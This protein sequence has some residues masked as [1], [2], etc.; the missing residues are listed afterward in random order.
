MKNWIFPHSATDSGITVETTLSEG[1]SRIECCL[2]RGPI[3]GWRDQDLGVTVAG[4]SQCAKAHGSG[5]KDDG[6]DDLSD[7]TF[8]VPAG[9]VEPLDENGHYLLQEQSK[10]VQL[11]TSGQDF[12]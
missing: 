1:N 4:I 3:D 7:E 2:F 8:P 6:E 5:Y 11:L 10:A 9:V 12:V